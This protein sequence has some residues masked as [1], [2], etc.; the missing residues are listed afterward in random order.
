MAGLRIHVRVRGRIEAVTMVGACVVIVVVVLAVLAMIV[1]MV[2]RLAGVGVA[3]AVV[4]VTKIAVTEAAVVGMAMIAVIEVVVP[5]MVVAVVV[6]VVC[7]GAAIAPHEERDPEAGDREAGKHAEPGIQPLGQDVAR[8]I[9]G[10][11]P[12]QIDADRMRR[13][14]DEAEEHGMPRRAA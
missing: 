5:V 4:I 6:M 2:I 7:S 3:V 13:G 14:H 10:D 9:Q 1:I 11:R 8:R 12:Q